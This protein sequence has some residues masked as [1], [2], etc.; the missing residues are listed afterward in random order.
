MVVPPCYRMHAWL[1]S[2]LGSASSPVSF[3][4]RLSGSLCRGSAAEDRDWWEGGWRERGIRVPAIAARAPA[5]ARDACCWSSCLS[6]LTTQLTRTTV[7]TSGVY[8]VNR[9]QT[10]GRPAHRPSGCPSCR[11]SS[12]S[13]APSC[14]AARAG[15]PWKDS[16]GEGIWHDTRRGWNSHSIIDPTVAFLKGLRRVPGCWMS[17]CF[18]PRVCVTKLYP[19]K[20]S[21]SLRQSISKSV[22]QSTCQSVSP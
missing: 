20:L 9:I 5:S 6:M 21:Q 13:H 14:P 22:C 18:R 7:S 16:A 10:N 8:P 15:L 17:L 4:S 2:T 19:I 12:Q 1:I 3:A 11:H